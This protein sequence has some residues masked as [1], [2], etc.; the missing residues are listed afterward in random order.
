MSELLII[1]RLSVGLSGTSSLSSCFPCASD[2]LSLIISLR[3]LLRYFSVSP[4]GIKLLRSSSEP[5][6][7]RW[8]NNSPWIIHH[9]QQLRSKPPSSSKPRL[10]YHTDWQPRTLSFLQQDYSVIL[11]IT[12]FFPTLCRPRSSLPAQNLEK[13]GLFSI[14]NNKPDD[15]LFVFCFAGLL[16]VFVHGGQ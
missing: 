7:Y 9:S 5:T 6:S 8:K 10:D 16:R 13:S 14:C 1:L 4:A 15:L 11:I 12:V 2:P 3:Y